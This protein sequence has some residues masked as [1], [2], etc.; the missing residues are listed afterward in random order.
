MSYFI[1]KSYSESLNITSNVSQNLRTC[2]VARDLDGKAFVKWMKEQG[3]H[4]VSEAALK[5]LV[6]GATKTE[7][8]SVLCLAAIYM[9]KNPEDIFFRVLPIERFKP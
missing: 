3:V 5:R 1:E 8:V 6:S 7:Q 9:N 4:E 2:L